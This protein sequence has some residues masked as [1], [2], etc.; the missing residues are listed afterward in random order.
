VRLAGDAGLEL[1]PSLSDV[2]A[3]ADVVLSVVPP[4]QARA[5]AQGIA[6]AVRESGAR[7]VV[8][9]LNAVSPGTMSAIAQELAGLP[10]VDG[11]ISGPPPTAKPGARLY[12][13][14][15]RAADV[16]ALPWGDK[17]KPVVLGTGIGA[18]SALKMSTASVYKGLN[19]L[20]TQAMRVAGRHGVLDEVLADLARNGLERS[21]G[22]AVSATK[23]HR[24]VDEMLQIAATQADA[25]LTPDLF[26]AFAGVYADVAGTELANGD[27]ETGDRSLTPAEIVA[28]LSK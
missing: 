7:P 28:Q 17:I 20:V 10:V 21:A 9:D 12:L 3:V 11:S 13:S 14:G 27:P 18:A 16:A 15:G 19:A 22:V 25:G 23:A 5:A 1:L 4:G 8:A 26:V 2:V 24:F 6:D